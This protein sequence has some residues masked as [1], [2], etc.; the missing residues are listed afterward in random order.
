MSLDNQLSSYLIIIFFIISLD[1]KLFKSMFYH[2]K[3]K[4]ILI[5]KNYKTYQMPRSF[6]N[7]LPEFLHPYF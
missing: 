2:Y 1:L 5:F 6:S 3:F 4:M 7:K